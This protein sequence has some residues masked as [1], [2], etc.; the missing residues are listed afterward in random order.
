MAEQIHELELMAR[1]PSPGSLTDGQEVWVSKDGTVWR[2]EDM[3]PGHW[4][5][6]LR[7]IERRALALYQHHLTRDIAL[8]EEM[9]VQ[10]NGQGSTGIALQMLGQAEHD[11]LESCLERGPYVA[12]AWVDQVP[13]VGRLRELVAEDRADAT[14]EANRRR[15]AVS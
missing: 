12:K 14:I 8:A 9:L 15:E 7:F 1:N 10:L 6:T 13:V 5:N 2:P 4:A 11:L 3:S